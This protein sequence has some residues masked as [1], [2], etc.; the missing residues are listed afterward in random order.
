MST[1]RAGVALAAALVVTT[2]IAVL[3]DSGYPKAAI[4]LGLLDLAI[5]VYAIIEFFRPDGPRPPQPG[6]GGPGGSASVG[7]GIA[8]GGPGGRGGDV[9]HFDSH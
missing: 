2:A 5:F 9:H 4:G 3:R 6:Q 8:I 1:K 7:T